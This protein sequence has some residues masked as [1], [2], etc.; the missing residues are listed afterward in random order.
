[1][2]VMLF[3]VFCFVSPDIVFCFDKFGDSFWTG[4]ATGMGSLIIYFA[5]INFY[6]R[7]KHNSTVSNTMVVVSTIEV[8]VL[9]IVSVICMIIPKIYSWKSVFI[10]VGAFALSVVFYVALDFVSNKTVK[11]YEELNEKTTVVGTLSAKA[12]LLAKKA[13]GTENEELS[14]KIYE[15]IKYSNHISNNNSCLIEKE[16]LNRL[17]NGEI[18]EDVLEL[19]EKRNELVK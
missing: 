10:C 18:S 8:L 17:D 15:S 3:N 11:G 14:K 12:E 5:F 2:V 9:V 6:L 1:M 7:R 4:Y 13:R 16:I 19:I